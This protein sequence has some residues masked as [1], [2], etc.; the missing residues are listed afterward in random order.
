MVYVGAGLRARPDS[1]NKI[2]I[3]FPDVSVDHSII[4]PNH[5]HLIIIIKAKIPNTGGHGDPPLRDII[6]R[7]K[8]FTTFEYN[9]VNKTKVKSLWQRNYYEHVIRNEHELQ[10]TREYI[11]GNPAKWHDDKYYV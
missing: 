8:S 6:G 10:K 2:P 4:M 11:I 9:Q 7:F 3:I 5:L 1:I